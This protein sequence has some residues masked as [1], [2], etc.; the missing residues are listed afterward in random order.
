[1]DAGGAG[2][3]KSLLVEGDLAAGAVLEAVSVAADEVDEGLQ[4]NL[5]FTRT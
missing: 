2:A 5:G 4:A 1:L 3:H